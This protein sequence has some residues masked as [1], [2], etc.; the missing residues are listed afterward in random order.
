MAPHVLD[1]PQFRQR[2]ILKALARV[3]IDESLGECLR[4]QIERFVVEKTQAFGLMGFAVVD[5][6]EVTKIEGPVDDPSRV[7]VRQRR[8]GLDAKLMFVIAE[9]HVVNLVAALDRKRCV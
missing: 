8:G 9:G 1:F 3:N 4:P 7:L 5:E 6:I 2:Y